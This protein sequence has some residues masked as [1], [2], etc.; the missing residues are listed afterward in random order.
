[1]KSFIFVVI[2]SVAACLSLTGCFDHG[3]GYNPYGYSP[4]GYGS[5]G[6]YSPWDSGMFGGYPFYGFA[7][8]PNWEDHHPWEEHNE[9]HWHGGFF[10]G[11]GFHGFRGGGFHGGGFHGR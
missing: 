9:N 8:R 3:Y 6:G 11:G 1:M 5:Y 4:F 2:V 7:G 10:H